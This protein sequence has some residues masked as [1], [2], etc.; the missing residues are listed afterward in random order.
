MKNIILIIFSAISMKAQTAVTQ[1]NT[2]CTDLFITEI[3]FGRN[4]RSDNTFDL[5]YAIEVFNSSSNPIQLNNY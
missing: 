4:L 5:N 1:P 2:D 3:T